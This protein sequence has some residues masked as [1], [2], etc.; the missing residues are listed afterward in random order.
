MDA[1]AIDV[2]NRPENNIH[3][4]VW[5]AIRT[6]PTTAKGENPI[7]IFLRPSHPDNKP[8]TGAKIMHENKSNDANQD[9]WVLSNLSSGRAMAA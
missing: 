9:A 6:Q 5:L 3:S 8:P 7:M 1:M 4:V 2:N